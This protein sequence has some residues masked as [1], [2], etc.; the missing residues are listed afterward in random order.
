MGFRTVLTHVQIVA[1]GESLRQGTLT[2]E[3]RRIADIAG[4]VDPAAPRDITIDGQG[5]FLTPGL[6]DVHTHGIC[7]FI[8]ENGPADLQAAAKCLGAFG[9]TCVLPTLVPKPGPELM[10]N[11]EKLV[12]GFSQVTQVCLPGL[13]L[14]GPFMAVTGAACATMPG[15]VGYLEELIAACRGRVAAMSISPETPGIIPVIQRLREKGIAVFI[16]HTRASAE[17]TEAAIAAGAQHGTHFY[18]V[19]PVP[20][21]KDGG[22]RPVGAVEAILADRQVSVDFIADGCHV[23]PMAI[24]AALAAKGPEGILLIT[25]SNIG[26]GLPAGEYDTP[27]G[28]RVKVRP[29]DGARHVE[30]NFLA[31]SA[32]TMDT[33][34][35]NLMSWLKL[36]PEQIWAMGTR[37]PARL[38]GLQNKGVLRVGADADLVLWDQQLRVR[39]TWVGGNVVFDADRQEPKTN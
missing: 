38:L 9:T 3:D 22:V 36:P 32:L 8:Y 4:R 20:P 16:T 19:F 26:S 37:N 27:W 30:K 39:K 10:K 1:P 23:H 17:E 14:E 34:M 31:G 35:R 12:D 7:H 15:D 28:Y 18:D 33:G 6:I 2:I 21:E 13:H 5:G 11:L 24:R 29:G 25:D